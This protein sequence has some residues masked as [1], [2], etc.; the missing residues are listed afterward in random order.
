MFRIGEFS[1]ISQTTVKTLHHY[2]DIGLL[3]PAEVDP[4]TG[5]RR[6]SI[7]QLPR[8]NRIV[9]LK[10]LGF[11]LEHI[12]RLLDEAMS[13][14]Q[15]CE[16]LRNKHAELEQRVHDEQARLARVAVRLRLI[17]QEGSMN[18]Y[19]VVI[20][21]VEPT[22]VASV[23]EIMPTISHMEHRISEVHTTL[24]QR[25]IRRTGPLMTLFFH[26]GFREHDLDVEVAVPVEASMELD[27]PLNSGARL[28]IRTLPPVERMASLIYQGPYTH[29]Q[30]SICSHRA[31]VRRARIPIDVARAR[32]VPAR[33]TRR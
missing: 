16:M 24:E 7:T 32:T 23:R 33:S 19:D 6:Y 13:H 4:L 26:T 5:Y 18:T 14:E 20:R 28:T 8:L 1:K 15:I 22:T 9:A 2:D 17:Q 27:V 12:A 21:S 31:L 11:S 30:R 29:P 10:E 25:G 3:K